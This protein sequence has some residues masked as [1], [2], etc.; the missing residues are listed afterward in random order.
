MKTISISTA[1]Y[2]ALWSARRDGEEN[3]DQ[4][5]SRL[6]G[7]VN[8]PEPKKTAPLPRP[9]LKKQ[10]TIKPVQVS[11]PAAKKETA[12]KKD[13]CKFSTTDLDLMS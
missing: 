1:T 6:L 9:V 8:A 5:L 7:A 10:K 12:P 4:I 11:Q 3:E 13:N 2:A